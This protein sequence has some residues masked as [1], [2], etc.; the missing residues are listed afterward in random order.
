MISDRAK[1]SFKR[2]VKQS[3]AAKIGLALTILVLFSALFAPVLAVQDPTKQNLS[4][5][6]T[7]PS[8]D[9]PMGTDG[10]GH[11]T[12]SRVLYGARVSVLVGLSVVSISCLLG[13]PL[14]IIS[15]YVGG[16]LDDLIMR[17][18]DTMLTIPGL[19]I[20]IT[21]FTV[22]GPQQISIPDP[23]VAFGITPDMPEE[24]ILPGTVIIALGATGWVRYARIARGEALSL[25]TQE[26][27]VAARSMGGNSNYIMRK[28]L[29]PN[30]I[31]PI[32]VLATIRIARAILSESSLAFLGFSGAT[33][34]WGL[35][36]AFGRQYLVSAWWVPLFPG[37]AIVLTIIGINLLGDVARDAIDPNIDEERGA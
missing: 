12:Y 17:G 26:F 31:T 28:H 30:S 27:I 18:A 11:D 4:E 29:I 24:F 32:L 10:L 5:A 35:D 37:L 2:E 1:K 21:I 34:S 14:G 16:R 3:P 15:G 22:V 7:A 36:I 13:V 25:R 19:I 33:I 23:F 8:L 20:A 9:H 6:R